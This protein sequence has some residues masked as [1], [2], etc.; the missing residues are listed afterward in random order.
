MKP[1][2]TS[3]REVRY[4]LLIIWLL[5]FTP[6]SAINFK[7]IAHTFQRDTQ[8]V[9]LDLSVHL[10]PITKHNKLYNLWRKYDEIIIHIDTFRSY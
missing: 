4:Y 10:T 9:V 6:V 3:R 8:D 7:E 1:I 2:N 5:A